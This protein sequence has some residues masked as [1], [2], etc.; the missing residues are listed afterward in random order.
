[1]KTALEKDRERIEKEIEE[2]EQSLKKDPTNLVLKFELEHLNRV[3]ITLKNL[4]WLNKMN[5]C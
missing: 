4:W 1:M 5:G 2:K 3:R